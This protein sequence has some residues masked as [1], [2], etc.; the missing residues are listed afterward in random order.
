MA[1]DIAITRNRGLKLHSIIEKLSEQCERKSPVPDEDGED[2]LTSEVLVVKRKQRKR[3]GVKRV[4]K[5]VSSRSDSEDGSSDEDGHVRSAE[6]KNDKVLLQLRWRENRKGK[7]QSNKQNQKVPRRTLIKNKNASSTNKK[8]DKSKWRLSEVVEENPIGPEKDLDIDVDAFVNHVP[9]IRDVDREVLSSCPFCF[10]MYDDITRHIK[11]CHKAE[12]TVVDNYIDEDH[13]HEDENEDDDEGEDDDYDDDDDGDGDDEVD[14]LSD[15][16]Y[17]PE[18][19]SGSDEEF[20]H[21]KRKPKRKKQGQQK[22]MASKD[23]PQVGPTFT[24]DAGIEDPDVNDE[25]GQTEQSSTATQSSCTSGKNIPKF[26]C[27][28]KGCGMRFSHWDELR[29]HFE[30][31]PDCCKLYR[32]DECHQICLTI[33]SLEKH[34]L[35]HSKKP[36]ERSHKCPECDAVFTQK[37]YLK[38]HSVVHTGIKEFECDICHRMFARQRSLKEHRRRHTGEKPYKCEY[39]DAAFTHCSSLRTHTTKHTGIRQHK[40]HICGKMFAKSY[41]LKMHVISHSSDKPFVCEV[42]GKAFKRPDHFK[43]HKI[44]HSDSKPF[45]CDTCQRTFNQKVCLRKHLPCREH[46]KQQKKLK[47]S[48]ATKTKTKNKPLPAAKRSIGEN[49]FSV[50]SNT[51]SQEIDETRSGNEATKDSNCFD[52]TNDVSLAS[53]VDTCP[54]EGSI[55]SQSYSPPSFVRPTQKLSDNEYY[56]E[57]S[58]QPER[59]MSAM[60]SLP[61]NMFSCVDDTLSL[62]S[63]PPLSS[64]VTHALSGRPLIVDSSTDLGS[65]LLSGTM[66]SEN[67]SSI[68][69]E[70]SSLFGQDR[71]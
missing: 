34:K 8:K 64:H 61:H 47:K 40:C 18:D 2:N 60:L 45:K 20:S 39:C 57:S 19:S 23:L 42:C 30:S 37:A 22:E 13:N 4:Y 7:A 59:D 5:E 16:S 35:L 71:L 43:Q 21:Q 17:I 29:K 36:K 56:S 51:N 25:N 32:C 31:R 53:S 3:N 27:G 38:R 6:Q 10:V 70:A 65:M 54:S 1:A 9:I 12:C 66:A 26:C 68:V 15:S 52:V 33:S 11:D 46:E 62:D 44:I 14:E 50:T 49:R 67:L 48:F 41:G 63:L 24:I 58:F 55:L 28:C 69:D